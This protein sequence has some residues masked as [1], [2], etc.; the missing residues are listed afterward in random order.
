MT[1]LGMIAPGG[2]VDSGISDSDGLE[3][4]LK[5]FEG[6]KDKYARLNPSEVRVT[7]GNPA[8]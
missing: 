7:A 8:R 3:A 1:P 4:M 2:R 5:Y 6:L